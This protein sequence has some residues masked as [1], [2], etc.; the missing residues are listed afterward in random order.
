M[1]SIIALRPVDRFQASPAGSEWPSRYISLSLIKWAG[2]SA[3]RRPCVER[4]LSRPGKNAAP[5]WRREPRD[6]STDVPIVPREGVR[7]YRSVPLHRDAVGAEF[8]MVLSV[9]ILL[10]PSMCTRPAVV[11]AG[12]GDRIACT[13]LLLPPVYRVSRGVAMVL[14]HA[15]APAMIRP[16]ARRSNRS[17]C[18]AR[19]CWWRHAPADVDAR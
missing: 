15:A 6:R 12:V 19:W 2:A 14:A 5:L 16:P 4:A 8:M 17:G 1:P 7:R 9:T 18:S 3:D 13:R 11:P 10:L